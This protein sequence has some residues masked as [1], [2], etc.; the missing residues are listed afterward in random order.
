MTRPLPAKIEGLFEGGMGHAKPS[1]RFV[2]YRYNPFFD[3]ALPSQATQLKYQVRG[4]FGTKA[5]NIIFIMLLFS[6][7]TT[8]FLPLVSMAY[9]QL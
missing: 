7:I 2:Q 5:F 4:H 6:E 9:I 3:W 8:F 1:G